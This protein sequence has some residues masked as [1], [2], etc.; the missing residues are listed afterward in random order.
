MESSILE[1]YSEK[2]LEILEDTVTR[3]HYIMKIIAKNDDE[4]RT[5]FTEERINDIEEDLKNAK[6]GH[7]EKQRERSY[8]SARKTVLEGINALLNIIEEDDSI[9]NEDTGD[10]TDNVGNNKEL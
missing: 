5:E 3:Y 4:E 10:D 1:N 9:G 6:Y 8:T 2:N 7:T